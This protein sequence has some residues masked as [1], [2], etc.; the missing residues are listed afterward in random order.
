MGSLVTAQLFAYLRALNTAQVERDANKL[1]LYQTAHLDLNSA[2]LKGEV[3]TSMF[4]LS[5]VTLLVAA[6][7]PLDGLQAT[8]QISAANHVYKWMDDKHVLVV[9]GA[10]GGSAIRKAADLA[11]KVH[12]VVSWMAFE[13]WQ[14]LKADAKLDAIKETTARRINGKHVNGVNGCDLNQA[15]SEACCNGKHVNGKHVNGVN[16]CEGSCLE[17][18]CLEARTTWV[19]RAVAIGAAGLFVLLVSKGSSSRCHPRT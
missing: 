18:W 12:G 17:A 5:R 2:A 16:G 8:K 7:D 11:A 1:F 9:L 6:L 15:P 3:G 10:S 14:A 13:D 19:A 4:D